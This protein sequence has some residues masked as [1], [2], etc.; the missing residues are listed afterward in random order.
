MKNKLTCPKCG[1]SNIIFIP[2]YIGTHGA[3]NNILTGSTI[4]NAVK[5]NRYVYGKCGYS[6][7][8]I[9]TEDLPKLKKKYGMK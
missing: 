1:C 3:G 2:G 6:E 9:N 7:E 4:F 8:W 5:V